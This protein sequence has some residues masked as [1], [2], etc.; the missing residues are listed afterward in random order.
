MRRLFTVIAL[1]AI[2]SPLAAQATPAPAP[3]HHGMGKMEHDPTMKAMGTGVLPTGWEMRLDDNARKHG[4][5][6]VDVKFVTM[7]TGFHVTSGPAAI[8]YNTNDMLRDTYTVKATFTQTK[9]P[10]HPEAYGIFVGGQN[11]Q[12]TTESYLYYIVRGDGK[13]MINHRAGMVVHHVVPWT[14]AAA[15]NKQ[16]AAGKATNALEIKVGEDSVHFLANGTQI[17][18]MDRSEM[19]G[20]STDGQI[21]IRVNHNLDVH[22]ADFTSSGKKMDTKGM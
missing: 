16:D 21:G 3:K 17:K 5:K 6:N 1:A 18:A 7:G 22:I 4:A 19:H 15:V 13:Y 14:D 2:A 11:L 20:F 8:Y 12:D 9:A 10:M